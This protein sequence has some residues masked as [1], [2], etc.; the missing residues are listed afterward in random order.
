[1]PLATLQ[2]DL[3]ALRRNAE[4][5]AALVAPTPLG[6]VVKANA[7]GHGLVPVARAL[8]GRVARF[9][10]YELDEALA[11]RE[12]GVTDPILVLGPVRHEDLDDAHADGIAITLWSLDFARL[13]A[14][15]ARRRL[16]PF[17]VHAKVDTG[18]ARLGFRPDQAPAALAELRRLPELRLEG[19]YTHLASAEDLDEGFTSLQHRRFIE[20]I[21][22]AL[23]E[24][25]IRHM[26]A[27]AAAMMWPETRLD[28]VRVGIA[29]YG[30]W[31]S[32]ES[33]LFLQS[34]AIRGLHDGDP[35]AGLLEPALTW[36]TRIVALRE[37]DAGEPVGYG[38]TWRAARRATLAT[39]PLGYA[40]GLDRGLSNRG[41]VLVDG[42]RCPI[43][44]RLCMDMCMIDVTEV[45]GA[46]LGQRVTLLG[47]DGQ[48]EITADD[49]ADWSGTIAYEVL[50]R[51]P[52]HLPRTYAEPP[53]LD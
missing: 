30:V 39:L 34:R 18:V 51:L 11:L 33:R 38:S 13:A 4:R 1:V 10:V 50:A 25:T 48:G 26:A 12:A 45:P 2:V 14:S 49:L 28:L 37:L 24:G 6:A 16:S 9:L 31:P 27:S 35:T 20:A 3:G 40:E 23:P 8:S 21:A 36:T 15:T 47:R 17:A 42:R 7:Y 44:G 46:H 41:A 53:A 5:L 29:L 22:G 52:L 19:C 43:A 32:R